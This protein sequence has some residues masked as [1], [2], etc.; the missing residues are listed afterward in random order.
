MGPV[1]PA[2]IIGDMAELYEPVAEEAGIE[3]EVSA[4]PGLGIVAN[5]ELVSQAVANL[6]DNAIKYSLR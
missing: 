6:V 4:A 5:R 1:D 3:L 2:S